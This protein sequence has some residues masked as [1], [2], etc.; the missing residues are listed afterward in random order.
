MLF[1]PNAEDEV[2]AEDWTPPAEDALVLPER[3]VVEREMDSR[4]LRNEL[5]QVQGEDRLARAVSDYQFSLTPT[6]EQA[7]QFAAPIGVRELPVMPPEAMK[8]LL[9]FTTSPEMAGQMAAPI[10]VRR[11]SPLA[12][13]PAL[14]VG[15]GATKAV[16]EGLESATAPV[17]LPLL[18]LGA[19][20]MGAETLALKFGSE[21]LGAG[22]GMTSAAQTPREFGA[23]LGHA[24]LGAG[25]VAGPAIRATRPNV[26][27][28]LSIQAFVRSLRET[29]PSPEV[30]PTPT[31][32]PTRHPLLTAADAV[33]A[34]S[35][36]VT[37]A[38]Q[39]P[40]TA[41]ETALANLRQQL[42]AARSRPAQ[43]G[44]AVVEAG[45]APATITGEA[46]TA[47]RAAPGEASDAAFAA[48]QAALDQ[49]DAAVGQAGTVPDSP[50]V[51]T[52]LAEALV[53]AAT[54]VRAYVQPQPPTEGGPSA[55]SEPQTTTVYGD[56]RPQPVE[57]KEALPAE[58][59]RAGVQPP[60]EAKG[61][62]SVAEAP[63]EAP[64]SAE[65][66]AAARAQ[67][68]EEVPAAQPVTAEE[69]PAPPAEGAKPAPVKEPWQMTKAQAF[70]ERERLEQQFDDLMADKGVEAANAFED[71]QPLLSENWP[72]AHELVVRNAVREGK[73]VPPEVLADYPDIK[74]KPAPEVPTAEPPQ[75]FGGPGAA[76]A[77]GQP[78]YSAAQQLT[79]RLNAAPKVGNA[80]KLSWR[81]RAAEAW[82]HGRSAFTS[83]VG[84]AATVAPTLRDIAR[85]VRSVRD[86][87]RRVAEFDYAIQSSAGKSRDMRRAIERTMRDKTDREAAAIVID[88][89]RLAANPSNPAEVRQVVADSIAALPA[90]TKPSIRKAF[91]RALDPSLELRQFVEDIKQF[92]SLREQDAIASDLFD[93]GLRSYYT[94][95]WEKEANMPDS[96]RGAFAS[97]K[98]S[99]YFQF[100]RQ[101]KLSTF[102]EGILEGKTPKLDPAEVLPFY[103]YS[104]DRAI[105]SRELIR[106]LTDLKASDGR[107][108]VEVSGVGKR[109]EG[110]EPSIL[111]KPKTRAQEIND[112]RAVDHPALRKWKWATA[113]EE[114]A[115]V[116]LQGDLV[117]HPEFYERVARMMHR[118]RLTPTKAMAAALKIGGEIKGLKLGAL[119]STFHQVHVGAHAAFH[120]TDPFM[121]RE[122]AWHTAERGID[123]DHPFVKDAIEKGHLKLA[124][125][126]HDLSL[127]AEGIGASKWTRH[128]PG[129]GKWSE[130]YTR[131]LF[132][133]YIPKLKLATYENA[134]A[135]AQKAQASGMFKGLGPDELAART[136][137]AV[138]NAYGELNHLFLGKHGRDPRFQRVL[139][140]AFLAPDFGEARLRFA[141]KAFTR[142]GHEERLAFATMA[143]TLYF[144]ARIANYLSHGDPE[145]E[146]NP[147]NWFRVKAGQHWWSMRSVAGDIAH[148]IDRPSQFL[149]VRLN[150]ITVQRG[151]DFLVQRDVNTGRKLG[152]GDMAERVAEAPLPLPLSSLA[153][154]DQR[155]WESFAGSM[156]LTAVRD[157]PEQDMKRLAAQWLTAHGHPQEAEYVP[158]DEPTYQRLRTMLRVGNAAKAASMLEGLRASRSDKQIEK[159]MAL[160]IDHPFTGSLEH[161]KMFQH[162]LTPPQRKLYLAARKEQLETLRGFY[163][164]VAA[165]P[166]K[167]KP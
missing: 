37:Q 120:W 10:G 155:A 46:M 154:D 30:V 64:L 59:G 45:Q 15:A 124:S 12:P 35:V 57:G 23:G 138:N 36:Q 142:Y 103:N 161:E 160:Y 130:T 21:A 115:P 4:R 82:S 55:R 1:T 112:Y 92:N 150:P 90:D 88:S 26:E 111:I 128:I 79:D 125:S 63:R 78:P 3:G 105:A 25:M 159:A 96:L 104:M 65:E 87:D 28:P 68:E 8:P 80:A 101:R 39:V 71:T 13:T 11:L 140:F 84:K 76:P 51:R 9:R 16:L 52:Q 2:V 121:L 132:E 157:T 162:G 139:R 50:A 164:L 20:P 144:G 38:G 97:D 89:E 40:R 123:W 116:F 69:R 72:D 41:V 152:I 7:A 145:I 153:R 14:E 22:L 24:A 126:P 67:L 58:E 106:R 74:A 95:V 77:G 83:T 141:E 31:V 66:Q 108:A 143:L 114:G 33:E 42:E 56:V 99:T 119:P 93:D 34:A 167:A 49:A 60:A 148:A 91:E 102:I 166:R 86:I 149:Y 54:A 75:E 98:V 18:P 131:W 137:D 127:F 165:N 47:G 158:T 136:G 133:D 5:R 118:D 27:M 17:M 113:T 147:R 29:Q 62:V 61:E 100:A 109:I 163:R 70:A 129:I 43:A 44:Q 110:A 146:A 151:W 156:G 94:H 53:R 85:G 32:A 135:R 117:V 48:A 107:P 19:T 134:L 81:E 122:R 6:R 73:P